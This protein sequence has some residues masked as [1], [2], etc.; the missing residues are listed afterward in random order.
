MGNRFELD[1]LMV[2]DDETLLNELRRVAALCASEVLTR[3]L[4]EKHGKAS[5]SVIVRR[6][7][8]WKAALERAGLA[9]R[10]SGKTGPRPEGCGNCRS[11]WLVS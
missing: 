9:E 7:K 11:L 10:Y 6:F 3:P 4:F 8:G 1:R 5:V 2:Y